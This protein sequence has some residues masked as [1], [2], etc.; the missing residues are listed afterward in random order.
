MSVDKKT[1]EQIAHL[2]RLSFDEQSLETMIKDMNRM[3]EF[4]NKLNELPTEGVE[5][6]IYMVNQSNVLRE[7]L[8]HQTITKEE[9]LKNAPKHDS[10]YFRVPKVIEQNGE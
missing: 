7:D 10:D 4:V 5:P 3:I 2:A 9:A 8:I 1:V 6:L